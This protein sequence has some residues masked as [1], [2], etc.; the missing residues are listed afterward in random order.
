MQID[1]VNLLSWVCCY[2]DTILSLQMC[3]IKGMQ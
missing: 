1:Y 3:K 2:A